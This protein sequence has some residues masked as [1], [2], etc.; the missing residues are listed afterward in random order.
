M[1]VLIFD[2]ITLFQ[3]VQ[4]FRSWDH[5]LQLHGKHIAQASRLDLKTL[6]G[7]IICHNVEELHVA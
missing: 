2:T 6:A 1:Q 5:G 7:I 4:T 3:N